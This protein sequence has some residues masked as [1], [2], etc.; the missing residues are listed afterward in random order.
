[1]PPESFETSYA[2]LMGQLAN[3]LAL[4]P[5]EATALF[6]SLRDTPEHASLDPLDPTELLLAV[7]LNAQLH[8][9]HNDSRF[10]K[11]KFLLR[12]NNNRAISI[13][14]QW[15]DHKV[16]FEAMLTTMQTSNAT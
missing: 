6:H 14:T 15:V 4:A 1:M 16:S 10:K 9:L 13:A 11:L 2:S 7:V 5:M 8:N 3:K 12:N